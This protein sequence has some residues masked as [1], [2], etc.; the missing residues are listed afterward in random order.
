MFNQIEIYET[1]CD[2]ISSLLTIGHSGKT[3][4][5]LEIWQLQE[6]INVSNDSRKTSNPKCYYVS[7]YNECNIAYKT[8]KNRYD[9]ARLRA[10]KNIVRKQENPD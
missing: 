8:V 6:Y 4:S 5:A 3:F 1:H 2:C 7:L 10:Y 9:I